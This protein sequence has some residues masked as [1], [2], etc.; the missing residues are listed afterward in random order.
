M[1]SDIWNL[2]D[3]KTSETTKGG[4]NQSSSKLLGIQTP[5]FNGSK[6]IGKNSTSEKIDTLPDD[7]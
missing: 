7:K 4:P 6:I 5:G 2:K 1:V 3:I